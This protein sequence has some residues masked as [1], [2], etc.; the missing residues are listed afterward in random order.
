MAAR[1]RAEERLEYKGQKASRAGPH[2]VWRILR[3]VLEGRS[4][5]RVSCCQKRSQA[6]VTE[7]RMQVTRISD[8]ETEK[9]GIARC[10]E[11]GWIMR[12]VRGRRRLGIKGER[13]RLRW[14]CGRRT[15]GLRKEG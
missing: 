5:R 12:R 1:Y 7:K 3:V 6:A 4:W 2:V 9:E 10:M 15:K 14:K 13:G 8:G 11:R